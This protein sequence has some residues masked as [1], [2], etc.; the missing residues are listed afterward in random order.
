MLAFVL[1]TPTI[2]DSRVGKITFECTARP[3]WGRLSH[4]AAPFFVPG[5]L[6]MSGTHLKKACRCGHGKAIHYAGYIRLISSSITA[7]I[8]AANAETT[9]RKTHEGFYI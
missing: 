6:T 5:I 8:R 1:W 7:D 4:R 3:V 9:S 2:R